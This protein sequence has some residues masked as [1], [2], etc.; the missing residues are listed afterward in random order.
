[1]K[2][3]LAL[4]VLAAFLQLAM[5]FLPQ[6]SNSPFFKYVPSGESVDQAASN[7]HFSPIQS[8]SAGIDAPHSNLGPW[9]MAAKK[10][11]EA[12]SNSKGAAKAGTNKNKGNN[13]G[14]KK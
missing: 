6:T 7:T 9:F 3:A 14:K 10:A 2:I 1:M 8:K 5:G 11:K 4:A 12:K 13:S